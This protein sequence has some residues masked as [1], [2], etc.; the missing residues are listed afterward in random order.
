M[1]GII[2]FEYRR[3]GKCTT[4]YDELLVLDRPDIKVMLQEHY[5][6]D[7]VNIDGERVL[8]SGAP[9]IWYVFPGSWHDVGRFHLRDG[10]LTGWYT[11]LC[12]PVEFHDDTWI[13]NDLFLD[14]WQPTEGGALWLDEDEFEKAVETG[15][16]D[17][18]VRQRTLNER[19]LIELQLKQGSWPPP[20][21]LDIDLYQVMNLLEL[22]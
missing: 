16:L 4:I 22:E 10:S 1:A 20:V 8:N 14:L 9:I 21:A 5:G 11:N 18:A 15:L 17:N 12:K 3:P 19:A 6:G 13:G 7:D 2:H